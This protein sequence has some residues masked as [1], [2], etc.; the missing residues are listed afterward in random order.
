M[1]A[2]TERSSLIVP[3]TEIC[4]SWEKVD[5]GREDGSD[6]GLEPQGDTGVVIVFGGT[7]INDDVRDAALGGEERDGGCRIH[8]KSGTEGDY[9]VRFVSGPFSPFDLS[10]V[11]VLPEADRRRFEETAAMTERRFAMRAK[12]FEV[13]RGIGEVVAGLAF[14]A[15]VSAVEFDEAFE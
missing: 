7:A 9:E 2:S 15:G 4:R 5:G 12:V 13:R 3:C 10:G 8:R 14:D 1:G 6:V 11:E